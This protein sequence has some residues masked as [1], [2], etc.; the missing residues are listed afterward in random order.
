MFGSCPSKLDGEMLWNLAKVT[1][2]SCMDYFCIIL[3]IR[4]CYGQNLLVSSAAPR[5]IFIPLN[6]YGRQKNE[7][8]FLKTSPIFLNFHQFN[9]CPFFLPSYFLTLFSCLASKNS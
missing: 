7:P 4:F 1:A 3:F 9:N 5:R 2:R 8:K 6:R